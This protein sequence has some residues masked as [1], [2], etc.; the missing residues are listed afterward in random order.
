[1]QIRKELTKSILARFIIML[2]TSSD[3]YVQCGGDIKFNGIQKDG[4]F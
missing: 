2:L 1:M 3:I 4:V